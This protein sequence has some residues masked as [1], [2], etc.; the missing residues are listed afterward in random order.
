MKF[1]KKVRREFF[2]RTLLV[3]SLVCGQWTAGSAKAAPSLHKTK[4]TLKKGESFLLKLKNISKKKKKTAVWSVSN[5]KI[6]SVTSKGMVNAKKKGKATVWVKIKGRKQ[7]LK[8]VVRVVAA[9]QQPQATGSQPAPSPGATIL[10]QTTG[11]PLPSAEASKSPDANV[12][13]S[14]DISEVPV[15]SQSPTVTE[16]PTISQAPT[17]TE[18]PGETTAPSS[19]PAPTDALSEE[20]VL[21]VVDRRVMEID[22][23][24]MTVYILDKTYNGSIH[25]SFCGVD[26]TADG[27]VKDALV[28]LKS[29]YTTKTNSANTLT[30]SRASGEP[31]WT[32]TVLTSGQ[33]YYMRAESKQT[34]DASLTD[35]GALY[36]KGDVSSLIQVY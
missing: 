19:S 32:I 22:G 12:T 33:T 26:Y 4:I 10:P 13:V 29:T 21:P 2:I 34:I 20:F 18:A 3:V 11:T 5:K 24:V 23:E 7:R 14:P 16:K 17:V 8:C 9:S 6:I 1:K 27:S 28:L 35:C 31:Y 15:I 36:F 30:M 25:I